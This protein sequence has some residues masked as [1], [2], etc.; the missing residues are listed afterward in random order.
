VKHLAK[1]LAVIL[2][3]LLVA[4]TSSLAQEPTKDAMPA[5]LLSIF[6]GF[7]TGHF[8]LQDKAAITFL[9]L[10]IGAYGVIIAGG[11]IAL[12]AVYSPDIYA[13]STEEIW[14]RAMTGLWMM[15]IGSLA[16]LGIRVWEIVDVIS[17]VN[18]MRASGKVAVRPAVELTPGNARVGVTLSY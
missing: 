18:E 16:Y 11:V 3:L 12:V 8:Y 10:D 14:D 7:G 15:L 13:Y 17:T 1:T 9:L 5:Y 4:A 2:V 6:L